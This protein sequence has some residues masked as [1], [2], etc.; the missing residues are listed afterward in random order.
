[1]ATTM[2]KYEAVVDSVKRKISDGTYPP[3]TQ[4]PTIPQLCL[5]YG[6]SKITIKKAMDELERQGYVTR[7]RGSGTYAKRQM[8]GSEFTRWDED[9]RIRGTKREYEMR[10]IKVTSVVYDFSVVTPSEQVARY[11][12][13]DDGFVYKICRRRDLDGR[14]CSIEYTYMPIDLIPNLKRANVEDSIYGYIN[15]ELGLTIGSAHSIFRA[16]NPTE[17]E[18]EWLGVGPGYPLFEVEQVAYLANG[19]PFEYSIT[20]HL[21]F[22]GEMR[23]VRLGQ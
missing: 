12:E 5:Q 19:E 13:L 22:T 16:V 18:Q 17:R 20:R 1:M 14:P 2:L 10:G 3:S 23:S 15:D 4:L 8:D 11:L 6:V 7:Q 21:Q 9:D